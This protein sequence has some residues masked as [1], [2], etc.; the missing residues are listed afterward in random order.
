M[1]TSRYVFV[2][3]AFLASFAIAQNSSFSDVNATQVATSQSYYCGQ[4][5]VADRRYNDTAKDY[6]R[7]KRT[8]IFANNVDLAFQALLDNSSTKWIQAQQWATGLL[9]VLVILMFISWIVFLVICC[10]KEQGQSNP[11]VFQSCASFAW[12]LLIL[13]IGIF[14]V[15]LIFLAFSEVSHRRVSCQVWSIGHFL[16]Q[17]YT[18]VQNGNTYVGIKNLY[19]LLDNINYE[20][21][22]FPQAINNVNSFISSNITSWSNQANN[23][24]YSVYLANSN[25]ITVGPLSEP[26][27]NNDIATLTRSINPSV[28]AD[29]GKLSA[30]L[31]SMVNTAQAIRTLTNPAIASSITPSLTQAKLVLNQMGADV[32]NSVVGFANVAWWRIMYARGGYWFILGLSILLIIF[33]IVALCVLVG[34]NKNVSTAKIMLA[35]FGFFAIWYVIAVIFLLAASTS[36]ATFCTSLMYV[37]RGITAPLDKTGI[38]WTGNVYQTT[39]AILKECTVG[40]SGNL[41][42]FAFNNPGSSSNFNPSV[43]SAASDIIAGLS[44]Q[45]AYNLNPR[46]TALPPSIALYYSA[47]NQKSNGSLEDS[48]GLY[49]QVQML[50]N[51]QASTNYFAPSSAACSSY[52]LGS[53]TCNAGGSATIVTSL[54]GLTNSTYALAYYNNIQK[55]ITNEAATNQAL[56]TQLNGSNTTAV[57][58]YQIADKLYWENAPYWAG[59]VRTIPL[60]VNSIGLLKSTLGTLDCRNLRAELFILE[61]HLCFDLNYWILILTIITAV[62][63]VLI[64]FLGWALFAA[65]QNAEPGSGVPADETP[66]I[67][68]V[69]EDGLD[70]ND[71]ELIPNM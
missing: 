47:L 37:N 1:K 40:N 52:T 49:D 26:N 69:K 56:M 44:A 71:K 55:Y 43:V 29:F 18:N 68:Q 60:T 50:T 14:F 4:T 35:L 6:Y 31:N 59:I 9:L 58:Y 53:K 24:L 63:A 66:A 7:L 46:K 23:A 61:D 8:S 57:Y 67:P 19:R 13:F 48:V 25:N 54:S 45:R 64:Y 16:V 42:Q 39:R 21:P 2:S 22:N 20:S 30:T 70:I 15:V 62:S 10:R 17:G 33:A 32:S 11:T 12:L 41:L 51:L 5:N 28:N 65:V 3:I 34:D 38:N 27:Q 36:I